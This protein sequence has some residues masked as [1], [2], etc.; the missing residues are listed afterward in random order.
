MD[1]KRFTMIDNEFVCEVCGNLVKPLN[2]TAR[3]HCPYCLSSKHVDILPGD[4]QENCHGIL[5]PIGIEKNKKSDFKI[6]Y[7]CK[8]CHKIRKNIMAQDDNY[9]F[10]VELSVKK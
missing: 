8:K 1:L 2:Y 3:D 9:D 5:E 10:I 7:K 6:I 4:R